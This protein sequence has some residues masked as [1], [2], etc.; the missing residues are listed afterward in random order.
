M[1][2][3]V[4]GYT[5]RAGFVLA[6]VGLTNKGAIMIGYEAWGSIPY[7]SVKAQTSTGWTNKELAP[8]F[9]GGTVV[10]RPGEGRR[11]SVVL[12]SA[13]RRWQCG[14]SIRE[15]TIQERA[16]LSIENMR[17][18]RRAYP[19]CGWF[20]GLLPH[21]SPTEQDFDSD[22]FEVDNP[23]H[24]QAGA[25]DAPIARQLDSLRKWRRATDQHR[26]LA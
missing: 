23:P 17:L 5:N 18:P 13:T 2:L 1:T 3:N 25:V 19:L 20:L 6:R 22:V 4:V 14:F 11:F 16:Y 24:N 7:G 15:A 10:L 8:H 12:P 21:K 9:T 26:L